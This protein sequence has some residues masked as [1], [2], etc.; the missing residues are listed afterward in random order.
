MKQNSWTTKILSLVLALTMATACGGGGGGGTPP[1]TT[2]ASGGDAG[3]ATDSDVPGTGGGGGGSL[4]DWLACLMFPLCF[5]W[6]PG[7]IPES[8]PAVTNALADLH[9]ETTDGKVSLVP[10]GYRSANGSTAD[11]V[12]LASATSNDGSAYADGLIADRQIEGIVG[13]DRDAVL[14]KYD[15]RGTLS[16]SH[17]FISPQDEYGQTVTVADDGMV[18]VTIVNM[19]GSDRNADIN[20]EDVLRVMFDG[21][22]RLVD[23]QISK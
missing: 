6:K 3:T 7:V 9:L 5:A 14:A 10:A 13:S 12:M 15:A 16:W 23:I 4:F 18:T 1:P 8:D 21:D 11:I 22:G 20:G 2:D 17:R 19:S